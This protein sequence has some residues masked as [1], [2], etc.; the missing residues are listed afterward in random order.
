M[1]IKKRGKGRDR[2]RGYR[3]GG[4]RVSRNMNEVVDEILIQLF[5]KWTEKGRRTNVV[6][7]NS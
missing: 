4:R 7:V 6:R 3:E 5:L 1:N 2:V